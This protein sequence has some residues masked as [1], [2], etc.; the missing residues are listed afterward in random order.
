[1]LLEEVTGAVNRGVYAGR[2]PEPAEVAEL[3]A[4]LS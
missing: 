4:R 2:W 3:R 1:M